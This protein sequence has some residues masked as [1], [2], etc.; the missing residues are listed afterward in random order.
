MITI[1]KA[2]QKKSAANK[3]QLAVLIDPDKAS[4]TS[5]KKIV[6]LANQANIGYFFLG[7]SLLMKNPQEEVIIFLR[8]HTDI[9]VLLFPG[10][11][12][13]LNDK[14]HGILLLS[15]ISG[16]NAEMLI[17][18]HVISAPFLKTSHLEILPTGYMLIDSGCTTTVAYM[19][20]TTPLPANKPEIA[21]CTAMAGEMLGLKIIYMDAGSGARNPV[22]AP[23]IAKVKES[24]NIPLIIG[25]GICTPA[26]A[27]T[28]WQSGADIVVVGNAI[29]KDPTLIAQ[30]A[31]EIE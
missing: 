11:N 23:M 14:A 19:S 9:P 21:A 17:G 10:N 24:V 13:Q 16:R 25:G 8:D 27:K 4:L 15:L 2:L 20:N 5:L 30:I 31:R 1:Y 6:K 7:G 28:A 29:E 26:L 22:P 18:R 12:L 3:K